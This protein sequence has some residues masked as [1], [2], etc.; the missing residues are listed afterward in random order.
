M[1]SSDTISFDYK[2]S[3]RIKF[4]IVMLFLNVV[5]ASIC[6]LLLKGGNSIST[7]QHNYLTEILI[8]SIFIFSALS[9][10]YLVFLNSYIS[11][12]HRKIGDA[13][14]SKNNF[15]KILEEKDEALTNANKELETTKAAKN[16]FL[17]VMS[18]ELRT[19]LSGIISYIELIKYTELSQTQLQDL[20]GIESCASSLLHIVEEILDFSNLEMEYIKLD[21]ELIYLPAML[22]NLK[23]RVQKLALEKSQ[24]FILQKDPNLPD[25]IMGD[26]KNLEHLLLNLLRNAVKFS[27]AGSS[28]ALTAKAVSDENNFHNVQFI[29]SDSGQGIPKNKQKVIFES[30]R[31]GED[32]LTRTYGG[33]GL[34]LSISQK[35][36]TLMRGKIEVESEENVGTSFFCT[37]PVEIPILTS[38]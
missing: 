7:S 6:F 13:V 21:N 35:L 24:T 36:A 38:N 8:C 33:V 34:G 11:N 37:L 27:S 5:I 16:Q 31:Q 28:I 4:A 10:K 12:L 2:V 30:F 1:S 14:E 9:L 20:N 32:S 29:V 22:S 18:H 3:R 23:Q 19:P 17:A 15:K 26:A 25:V